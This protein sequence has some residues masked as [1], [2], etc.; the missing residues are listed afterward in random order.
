[1]KRLTQIMIILILW[2]IWW[3]GLFIPGLAIE[4]AS[5]MNGKK[6]GLRQDDSRTYLPLVFTALKAPVLKWSYGGC[7]SSWCQTG[8]YSS[9][10]V[11]NIDGDPQGEVVAGMYD[12][13]ALDGETGELQWRAENDSRV[14]PGVALVDLTGDGSLE[15]VTGRGNDQLTVYDVQ[16][17]VLWSRH[18]FGSGEVRTLATADIDNDGDPDLL[19]TT[20]MK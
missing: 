9:P 11:A 10:V 2:A 20:V 13:V 7:F 15:I 12:L 1:M 14:W 8:W 17:N 5:I 19:V 6:S 4:S 3:E 18:P 16:G